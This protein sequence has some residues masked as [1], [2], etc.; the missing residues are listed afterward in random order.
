MPCKEKQLNEA[1]IT[2]RREETARKRKHLS[3]KSLEGR[4]DQSPPDEIW[5]R[6]RHK[7]L[8]RAEDRTR[9]T[10]TG[11]GTPAEGEVDEESGEV[12]A[13]P[14]VEVVL[15][16]YRWILISKLSHSLYPPRYYQ[17]HTSQRWTATGM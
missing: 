3:E 16:C 4:D 9:A 10:H 14:V 13:V 15:T 6:N 1:E 8:V 7:Q 2:L 5:Q 11:N 12:A 17:C